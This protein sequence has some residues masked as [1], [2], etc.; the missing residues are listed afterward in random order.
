MLVQVMMQVTRLVQAM[1][2]MMMHETMLV[3][4]MMQATGDDGACDFFIGTFR[5]G[6]HL[7]E[8]K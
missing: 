2:Q 3:Q 8:N 1:M 7:L 5:G 4:A 6:K